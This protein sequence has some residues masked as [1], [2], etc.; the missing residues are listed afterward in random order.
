MKKKKGL[1]N[2]SYESENWGICLQTT[3]PKPWLCHRGGGVDDCWDQD[4][5]PALVHRAQRSLTEQPTCQGPGGWEDPDSH[6]SGI[7]SL[8]LPAH[9]SATITLAGSACH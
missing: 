5:F 6:D 3:T 8:G 4:P 9:C 1:V 2:K 7:D